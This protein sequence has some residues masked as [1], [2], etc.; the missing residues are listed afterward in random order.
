MFAAPFGD[1]IV[2]RRWYMTYDLVQAFLSMLTGIATAL[3]RMGTVIAFTVFSLPRLDQTPLPAWVGRYLL[4]L[5]TATR[6][7]RGVILQFNE[8]NHPVACVFVRLLLEVSACC[9]GLLVHGH[10][11]FSRLMLSK[12][13]C[14]HFL[15]CIPLQAAVA[16]KSASAESRLPAAIR[17][18]RVANR[19][20]V[21]MLL[22]KAP[23]LAQFRSHK[24]RDSTEA[25]STVNVLLALNPTLHATGAGSTGTRHLPRK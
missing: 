12:S 25:V 24:R 11:Y 6:S 17:R 2:H 19:F 5:D 10:Y 18:R 15:V 16:R 13:T 9:S 7:Y 20:R 23:H 3:A 4:S 21:L 8:F 1:R 22:L 14:A